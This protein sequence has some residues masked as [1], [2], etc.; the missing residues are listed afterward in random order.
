MTE[1]DRKEHEE[2][3]VFQEEVNWLKYTPPHY[4]GDSHYKEGFSTKRSTKKDPRLNIMLLKY[5][6][7]AGYLL[8]FSSC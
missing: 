6:L 8:S 1:E 7:E 4:C 5:G 3:E 2:D